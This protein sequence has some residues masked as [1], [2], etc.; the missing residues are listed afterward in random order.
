VNI[1]VF[2][3][4][5]LL[6]VEDHAV[7]ID[8]IKNTVAPERTAEKLNQKVEKPLLV[9]TDLP[10]WFS[11]FFFFRFFITSKKPFPHSIII[12]STNVKEKESCTSGKT[13]VQGIGCSF[14]C[15]LS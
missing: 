5:L 4:V 2:Q 1:C 15:C 8:E 6:V 10:F 13:R 9:A 11:F 7:F 3:L 14:Q 12:R